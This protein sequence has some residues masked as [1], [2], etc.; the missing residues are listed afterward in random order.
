[1][2][3]N[4]LFGVATGAVTTLIFGAEHD[5]KKA[6]AAY[7]N[8]FEDGYSEGYVKGF[9]AGKNGVFI[10]GLISGLAVGGFFILVSMFL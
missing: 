6:A 5:K 10:G 7:N 1:M 4:F 9:E 8:G 2:P 3:W